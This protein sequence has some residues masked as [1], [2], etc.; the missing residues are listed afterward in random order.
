MWCTLTFSVLFFFRFLIA[1]YDSINGL[2]ALINAS[3]CSLNWTSGYLMAPTVLVLYDFMLCHYLLFR[4]ILTITSIH[5]FKHFIHMNLLN[6]STTRTTFISQILKMRKINVAVICP[7]NLVTTKI[8]FMM[9]L[10]CFKCLRISPFNK[11]LS[12]LLLLFYTLREGGNY[13]RSSRSEGRKKI[14]N[15]NDTH[16]CL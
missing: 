15:L 5:C 12:C 16:Y 11:I 2:H 3:W 6:F 4:V 7:P 9:Y 10:K 8:N 14:N 1:G 13:N